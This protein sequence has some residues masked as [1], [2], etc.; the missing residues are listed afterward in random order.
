MSR[1]REK[2]WNYNFRSG[3]GGGEGGGGGRVNVASRFHLQFFAPN[4]HNR[5]TY[6][7]HFGNVMPFFCFDSELSEFGSVSANVTFAD[8][9]TC[10]VFLNILYFMYTPI[11]F[12]CL[13]IQNEWRK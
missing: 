3:G 9:R 11:I 12:S 5:E 10:T 2:K 13:S 8:I 4:E 6:F 1:K 7:S